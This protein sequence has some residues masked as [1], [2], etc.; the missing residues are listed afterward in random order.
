MKILKKLLALVVAASLAF[1]V[2]PDV[3]EASTTHRVRVVP[4]VGGTVEVRNV[5]TNSGWSRQEVHAS[6]NQVIQIRVI[7]DD[8]FAAGPV[9]GPGSSGAIMFTNGLGSPDRICASS[10]TEPLPNVFQFSMRATG[11]A[12]ANFA[13]GA[14][15]IISLSFALLSGEDHYVI[16]TPELSNG[17]MTVTDA[18]GNNRQWARPGDTVVLTLL[19][20][21]GFRMQPD[22]LRFVNPGLVGGGVVTINHW[23]V[24]NATNIAARHY[25]F[26]FIM[27]PHNLTVSAA[28]AHPADIPAPGTTGDLWERAF[29]STPSRGTQSWRNY[30]PAHS[31]PLPTFW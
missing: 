20:H 3:A 12:V 29:G 11:D 22:S 15:I 17:T 24:R 9:V 21:A 4:T 10:L 1:G 14:D 28:F 5:T 31:G 26:E 25:R 30:A 6:H 18:F 23:P 13:P 8:E 19:P 27:P 7:P 2:L 16:R